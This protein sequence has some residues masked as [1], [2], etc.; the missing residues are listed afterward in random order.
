MAPRARPRIRLRL[1]G[2]GTLATWIAA[3]LVL[4]VTPV[5]ALSATCGSVTLTQGGVSPSSGT[6]GTQFTFTV[7]Y[8]NSKGGNPGRAQVRFGDSTQIALSGSGDTTA[9]V[10]YAGTT[11]KPNGTWTYRFRFRTLGS[12]CE[13]PTDTFVVAT[14]TPTPQPTPTPTPKPTPPPTP[15][16]TPEPTARSTPR[17]TPKPTPKPTPKRAA[18][19]K[20]TPKPSKKP[21]PSASPAGTSVA[22]PGQPSPSDR[23]PSDETPQPRPTA[24]PTPSLGAAIGRSTNDGPPA[25]GPAL[26]LAGVARGIGGVAVNPLVVWLLTAAG[27]TALYLRLVRHARDDDGRSDGLVLATATPTLAARTRPKR[28]GGLIA[29]GAASEA[30]VAPSPAV[31]VRTFDASPA[32]GVERATIGYHKVRISSK[33]DAVRSVELRRLDRGDEVEILDSYEGFLQVR[34]PDGVVGWIMRHTIV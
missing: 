25:A 22:T 13:T 9:G 5:L 14:P 18:T 8:T 34:T 17:A 33:P 4:T 24:S 28:R 15:K 27:G 29:V 30:A 32:K 12:W 11:T 23:S 3:T 20:P 10:V 19:P 31:A 2:A 7:T 1:L 16:P 21:R 6:P 26:D